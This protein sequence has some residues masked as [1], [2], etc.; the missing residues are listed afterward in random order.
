LGYRVEKEKWNHVMAIQIDLLLSYS[1]RKEGFA[2]GGL[3]AV[4]GKE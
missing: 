2:N 1:L 4:V 3:Y